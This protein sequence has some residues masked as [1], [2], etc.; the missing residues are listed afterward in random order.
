[1]TTTVQYLPAEPVLT[2]LATLS[3]KLDRALAEA[4]Q[5]HTPLYLPA[6]QLGRL[7]GMGKHTVAKH[8]TLARCR[9][10][11]RT[12]TPDLED[13]TRCLTLYNVADFETW[14][15]RRSNV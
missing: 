3:S 10:A 11:I 13:G 14:L 9:G 7:F 12:L 6:G 4:E 5:G 8:L 15:A 1:M 2:E